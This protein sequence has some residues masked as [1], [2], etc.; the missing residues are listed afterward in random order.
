MNKTGFSMND[1]DLKHF[2]WILEE[3]MSRSWIFERVKEDPGYESIGYIAKDGE[4]TVT[5]FEFSIAEQGFQ[6]GS[7]G[8]DGIVRKGSDIVRMTRDVA[9]KF[10]E[11]ARVGDK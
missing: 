8:H 2:L 6:K 7:R 5:V 3:A 10:F 9:K 1:R 4:W 11:K